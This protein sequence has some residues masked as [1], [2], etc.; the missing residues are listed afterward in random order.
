MRVI[1]NAHAKLI[2][3]M[4]FISI[5]DV[6]QSNLVTNYVVTC[7]LDGYLKVWDMMDSFKPINEFFS[8]KKWLYGLT[9]DMTNLCLYCNGEGKHFPQKIL[10][11]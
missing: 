7:G 3:D 2:S 10:Y 4:E 8:S 5:P 9:F 11:I 6:F 1:Y